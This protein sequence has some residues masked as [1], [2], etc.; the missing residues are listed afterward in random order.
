MGQLS[1][2]C[3]NGTSN[4]SMQSFPTMAQR[5]EAETFEMRLQQIEAKIGIHENSLVPPVLNNHFDLNARGLGM[6]PLP[7]LAPEQ[8]D[9]I[10]RAQQS[11]HNP[12]IPAFSAPSQ[13]MMNQQFAQQISLYLAA[14]HAAQNL[15][16]H[17]QFQGFSEPSLLNLAEPPGLEGS[18]PPSPDRLPIPRGFKDA[19]KKLGARRKD[20][21]QIRSRTPFKAGLVNPGHSNCSYSQADVDLNE[22][23]WAGQSNNT[24]PGTKAPNLKKNEVARADTMKFQLQ[25]LQL[26][27]PASVFIARGINKLGFDSPDILKAH[28]SQYGK[29]KG[30]YVSHS[31]VKS[32]RTGGGSETSVHWRLRAALTGFVVMDSAEDTLR[33]LEE[34]PTQEVEGVTVRLQKFENLPATPERNQQTSGTAT[35]C[36]GTDQEQVARSGSTH[37]EKRVRTWKKKIDRKSVV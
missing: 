24:N 37:A 22:K 9:A 4:S 28:F 30:V 11:A 2:F 36:S 15:P 26:E 21:S 25:E 5:A 32:T 17:Q 7:Y 29:V 31:R 16:Q 13:A 19:S 10:V 34:G 8:L 35:T 23:A 27:D 3:K 20:S 12:L 33:I 14:Q 6:A 1:K 18:S